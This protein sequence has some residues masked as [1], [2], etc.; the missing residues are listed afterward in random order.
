[1]VV[2]QR[3]DLILWVWV[4]GFGF[5]DHRLDRRGHQLGRCGSLI[6]VVVVGIVV[7]DGG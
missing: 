7:A 2:V 5:V 4:H 3:G 1:M 6:D